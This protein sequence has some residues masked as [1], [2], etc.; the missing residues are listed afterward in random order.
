MIGKEN[1][2]A[3]PA[4]PVD[5]RSSS[6][7][8]KSSIVKVQSLSSTTTPSRKPLSDKLQ[9]NSD[10]PSAVPR[11]P[12][13]TLLS[14]P[15]QRVL[16]RSNANSASKAAAPV[17]ILAKISSPSIASTVHQQQ[18]Y[19][20]PTHANAATATTT[21]TATSN[22]AA[23]TAVT[24]V[25]GSKSHYRQTTEASRNSIFTPTAASKAVSVASH[26]D[27]TTAS[28]TAV[29][30]ATTANA[31]VTAN[32]ITTP[33]RPKRHTP[34]STPSRSPQ[35]NKQSTPSSD[36][37]RRLSNPN[38]LPTPLGTSVA[39]TG[40]ATAATIA[41][42]VGATPSVHAI[43]SSSKGPKHGLSATHGQ[44]PQVIRKH[45]ATAAATAATAVTRKHR[46]AARPYL[47]SN[48]S[49]SHHSSVS[50]RPSSAAAAAVTT[51]GVLSKQG[52]IG[53]PPGHR[54][55]KGD[56]STH[57]TYTNNINT[58][59][60]HRGHVPSS[61]LSTKATAATASVLRSS[62]SSLIALTTPIPTAIPPS[63][64]QKGPHSKTRPS[65]SSSST[66]IAKRMP[67]RQVS[68]DSL[69]SS[70]DDNDSSIGN[71]N[72]GTFVNVADLQFDNSIR[73]SYSFGSSLSPVQ[74]SGDDNADAD[75]SIN[76]FMSECTVSTIGNNDTT[77]TSTTNDNINTWYSSS[78]SKSSRSILKSDT[79]IFFDT[80]PRSVG[81]T[82]TTGTTFSFDASML[83]RG[84]IAYSNDTFD[85]TLQSSADA[86]DITDDNDDCVVQCDDDSVSDSGSDGSSQYDQS[87]RGNKSVTTISNICYTSTNSLSLSSIVNCNTNIDGVS[88]TGNTITYDYIDNYIDDT[89]DDDG[90]VDDSSFSVTEI[91]DEHSISASDHSLS[92][93]AVALCGSSMDDIYVHQQ[94]H[95][96]MQVDDDDT[97][98]RGHTHSD[99]N[100]IDASNS[101]FSFSYNATSTNDN[102][103]SSH[104]DDD[105]E[106]ETVSDPVFRQLEIGPGLPTDNMYIQKN[107]F[108]PLKM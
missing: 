83:N 26:R 44:Q 68:S 49:S 108:M 45:L 12:G 69:I 85:G 17:R 77:A 79:S 95:Q 84:M 46:D 43:Q 89:I 16:I 1:I 20:S 27:E 40:I 91:M 59:K 63:F 94:H 53:S 99:S 90:Y 66:A 35:V 107:L 15:P 14:G 10:T 37:S 65:S 22:I 60:H 9:S 96:L 81:T 67:V 39:I 48:A 82:T 31:A 52:Y 105:R 41:V 56:N 18:G 103:Y 74:A 29:T 38:I 7:V 101:S 98:R 78:N 28:A 102:A 47:Q 76:T 23:A 71:N 100:M 36:R 21:A 75:L 58:N 34:N 106:K 104:V 88:A 6:S 70:I 25:T 80:S 24:A 97:G 30:T 32:V 64:K 2:H 11:T 42:A 5:S 72:K 93:L 62:S 73:R 33:Q 8:H 50:A 19:N 3:A 55:K 4:S 57:V 92:L 61:S 86:C 87:G 51:A 13:G 54:R